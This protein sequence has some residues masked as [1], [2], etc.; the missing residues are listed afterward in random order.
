MYLFTG[1]V[2]EEMYPM[3]IEILALYWP[4]L[5]GLMAIFLGTAALGVV[6]MRLSSS[7]GLR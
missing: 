5:S 3:I 6:L 4:L 1:P 7:I 2:F